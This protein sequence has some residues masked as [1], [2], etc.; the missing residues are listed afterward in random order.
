MNV[1]PIAAFKP[2]NAA[3]PYRF[4]PKPKGL[5]QIGRNLH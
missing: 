5:E 4:L 1:R 3:D 2:L